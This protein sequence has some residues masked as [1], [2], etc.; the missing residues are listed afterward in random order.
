MSKQ[1]KTTGCKNAGD[2][3]RGVCHECYI[4]YSNFVRG[5]KVTWAELESSGI[6]NATTRRRDTPAHKVIYK[7]LAE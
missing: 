5:G 3:A 4:T 6:V 1:C 7:L 2:H